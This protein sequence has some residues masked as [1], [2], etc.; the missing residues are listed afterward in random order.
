MKFNLI[1]DKEYKDWLTEIKL[2]VRHAQLKAAVKVNTE[3][4]VLY[5]EL[6][7]DI[8]AKQG[9][10]K[11]G[12][13]LI[14]RL[15]KDLMSEFPDI[16][17]F[18]RSNLMYIK[19]WYLFYSKSSAIVQQA[20]GQFAKQP[21]SQL[22]ARKIS[23]QPVGQTGQQVIAQITQI[24][25]G[26]NIAIISKCKNV[27]EALYY[28]QNTITHNWSRSVLVHQIE[29]GLYKREGKSVTN[30]A[31]TLPKPQ[32]DLAEQTLKN[33][34][35]FDFLSMTKKYDERELENALLTH[36]TQ[37][38]LELGAGFAFLG[39]Q[40]PVQVGTKEFFIDLLFY[41]TRLHCYVVVELKT[42]DF[43]PA[44]AGQL[45][46]YIKAVDSQLRKEGDCPTIGLLLC[47]NRDKLVAE[48]ALSDINKPIGVSEYKLTH[49]LPKKLK[50][51]LPTI[52][53]I[54]KELSK[55]IIKTKK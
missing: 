53:Q 2:K 15:S 45:N 12:E 18:S 33:P 51:S 1:M 40:V 13:G 11:W 8:V 30:F 22:P 20:V 21:V 4:L 54:E 39:R 49:S 48:Y 55:D 32:S 6:G 37:F 3:L 50:S 14:D 25:W 9:H 29:S 42:G 23:Q 26:H 52:E 24:P 41:H 36:V 38:L 47:K 19:K 34:Y 16:K 5:W 17:G 10:T 43:E 28:V 27:K 44:Y 31:L 46:F 35:I 7:A